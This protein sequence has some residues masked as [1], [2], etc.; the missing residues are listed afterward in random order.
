MDASRIVAWLVR[1]AEDPLTR[2]EG[3]FEL[4]QSVQNMEWREQ[5][6]EE[7][8]ARIARGEPVEVE[9]DESETPNDEGEGE[10]SPRKN[11]DTSVFAKL[12]DANQKQTLANLLLDRPAPAADD[13]D[14]KIEELAGDNELIELVKRWGDPRLVGFLLDQLRANSGEPYAAG[15][16]MKTIAE[17]LNDEK[18]EEIADKYNEIAYEDDADSVDAESEG[19]DETA[20]EAPYAESEDV[21]ANGEAEIVPEADASNTEPEKESVKPKKITYKEL[22]DQLF[23]KFIESVEKAMAEKEKEFQAES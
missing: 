15:Q 11:V 18:I 7:R 20:V 23:S 4:L 14:A 17:I 5:A 16:T 13:K 22:R 2:W 12:I 21:L 3:T 6:A 9:P 19:D 1:C 10:E 8:K